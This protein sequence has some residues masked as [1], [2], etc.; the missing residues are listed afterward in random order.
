MYTISICISFRVV[1]PPAGQTPNRFFLGDSFIYICLAW[2]TKERV[3]TV[4]TCRLIAIVVVILCKRRLLQHEWH[5][6]LVRRFLSVCLYCFCSESCSPWTC[7]L[8]YF[9]HSLMPFFMFM[10]NWAVCWR[11]KTHQFLYTLLSFYMS[12]QTKRS[13][14]SPLN[15]RPKLRCLTMQCE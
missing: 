12:Q 10:F 8:F 2:M 6:Q 15:S 5:A 9:C 13:Q 7:I 1:L 3:T 4:E 14:S 11:G